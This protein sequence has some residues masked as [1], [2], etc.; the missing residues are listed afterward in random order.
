M[1]GSNHFYVLHHPLDPELKKKEKE[2]KKKGE[3]VKEETPTYEKAQEEIAKNSG[4]YGSLADN[5]NTSRGKLWICT[6]SV[7]VLYRETI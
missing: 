6:F 1:F 2:A 7:Y 3:T 5:K 4:F